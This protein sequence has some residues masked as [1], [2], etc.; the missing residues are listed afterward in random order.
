VARAE[1]VEAVG[2][3]PSPADEAARAEERER[4]GRAVR[5][6]PRK[7]REVVVLHYVEEM[8][9]E[10]VAAALGI[11][12]AAARRRALRAREMLQRYLGGH[13]R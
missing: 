13:D 3:G 6:L 4:V 5:R 8:G 2:G 9:Y 11:R 7:Y 1:G 12:P 10:E